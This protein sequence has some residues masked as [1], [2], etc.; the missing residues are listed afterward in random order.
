[1]RAALALLALAGCQFDYPVEGDIGFR[2]A[3]DDD[4]VSGYCGSDGRCIDQ[5]K[6]GRREGC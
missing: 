2:C 4:C 3:S 1:M 6:R 5:R